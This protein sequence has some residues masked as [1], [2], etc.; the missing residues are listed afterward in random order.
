MIQDVNPGTVTYRYSHLEVSE[1]VGNNDHYF[2]D[3]IV[4]NDDVELRGLRFS[5][6]QK[7]AN[8][9]AKVLN[10]ETFDLA[11]TNTA[12][13]SEVLSQE[14]NNH[15]Q[16]IAPFVTGYSYRLTFEDNLFL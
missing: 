8:F 13:S 4:C 12:Y 16:W 2:E 1:C 9:Y 3:G 11:D 6:P 5:S 14:H 15:Y 7:R 10:I